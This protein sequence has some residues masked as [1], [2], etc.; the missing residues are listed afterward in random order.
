MIQRFHT[1]PH[2]GARM[3][4]RTISKCK[5]C[6]GVQAL[7]AQSDD[8][9]PSLSA[10]FEQQVARCPDAIALVFAG[11]SLTY[12][13]L[14]C[15]STRLGCVLQ[16]AGVGPEVLVALYLER[17]LEMVIALLAVLK[18]GGA[19]V[20]LDTTAPQERL[21]FMLRDCKAP[22]VLTQPQIQTGLP[23]EYQGQVLVLEKEPENERNVSDTPTMLP[24]QGH[25]CQ[26]VNLLYTSGSTGQPKGV[27]NTSQGLYNR[28]FW[29]QARY[30]LQPSDRV[31]QKTP[32]S[33]D[34]S[35][36]EVF[37]P[38]YVGATLVLA[39]PDGHRDSA[40][41]ADLIWEQ[42]IT[43][44]HFVPSMLDIF[45]GEPDLARCTTLRYVFCSGEALS[46]DL[47]Q[48]YFAHLHAELHNLYGPTEAAIDV[49][50]WACTAD[51]ALNTVP[52][53]SPI[54]N[55]QIILL[56]QDGVPVPAGS[57]GELCIGGM[58][59]ARGYYG[60]PDLT[61]ERF[62]PHPCSPEPGARLY[63][64]GDLAYELADST[65]A[66]VGRLDH[67]VKLRG[68]RIELGEIEF[69]LGQHPAV[70][71]CLV[72]VQLFAANDRRLVAYVVPQTGQ[73]PA[74][75]DLRA[76]LRLSLPEYMIPAL[77]ILIDTWPLLSNGKI[78]RRALPA[79]PVVKALSQQGALLYQASEVKNGHETGG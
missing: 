36:W 79:V 72:Q 25:P 67:Q 52:I 51:S 3:R 6:K 2:K 62:R 20:P 1:Q 57:S 21:A 12:R 78:D 11:Q 33:F 55:T 56:D 31:L 30:Q 7:D 73:K 5:S 22:I 61:A 49:T 77:F 46:V 53:G 63:Q 15:A 47:Q 29:M 32:Y 40:Y 69:S 76:F 59:L 44:I 66:F 9:I 13:A 41:L 17:S 64:T 23:T 65:F 34:V 26:A 38:L 10:L 43:V 58:G 19:Y 4:A 48:R 35:G 50:A 54:S 68:Q 60:R 42:G 27:I 16:A 74:P 28:L 39:R 45:L 18:A 70:R 37:W 8:P 75:K 24:W 14:D 71:S